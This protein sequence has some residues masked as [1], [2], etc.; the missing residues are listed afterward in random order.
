MMKQ[1]QGMWKAEEAGLNI[2]ILL[3]LSREGGNTH[4]SAYLNLNLM[5][6]IKLASKFLD[7][8]NVLTNLIDLRSLRLTTLSCLFQVCALPLLGWIW[9]FRC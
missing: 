7:I 4:G 3:S 9:L 2:N 8:K 6:L 5:L 1:Q